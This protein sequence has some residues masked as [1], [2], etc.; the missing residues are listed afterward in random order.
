V[1]VW[2]GVAVRDAVPVCVEV[3]VGVRVAVAL[4]VIEFVGE[5][6]GVKV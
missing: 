2:E 3:T 4:D 6:T 1:E 5:K